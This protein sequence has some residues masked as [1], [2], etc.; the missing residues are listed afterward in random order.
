MIVLIAGPILE[1]IPWSLTPRD[2]PLG[3]IRWRI[4][5]LGCHLSLML[6]PCLYFLLRALP[7]QR[8][9]SERIRTIVL[10]AV[11]LFFAYGG[12]RE[13][14]RFWADIIRWIFGL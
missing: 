6:W 10:A 9:W 2:S 8:F 13:L 11:C 7:Q 12:T 4:A 1:F 5:I 14:I 3:N